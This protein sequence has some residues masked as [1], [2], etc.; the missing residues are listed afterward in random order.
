MVCTVL[1]ACLQTKGYPYMAVSQGSL[2]SLTWLSQVKR[3]TSEAM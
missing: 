2:V 1:E 3:S